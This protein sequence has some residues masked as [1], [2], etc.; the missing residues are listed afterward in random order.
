MGKMR[1]HDI[2][3]PAEIELVENACNLIRE[4]EISIKRIEI[5]NK[6][7]RPAQFFKNGKEVIENIV[8]L[9]PPK[10]RKHEQ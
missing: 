8:Y 2:L 9:N 10:E 4:C 5:G 7:I 6:V 1:V 3:T